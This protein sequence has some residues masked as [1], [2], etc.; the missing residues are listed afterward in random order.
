[1]GYDYDNL[2]K[3]INTLSENYGEIEKSVIGKSVMGRDIFCL[4]SGTGSNNA[5]LL[6]AYH[7]LEYLTS[8]FLMKFLSDFTA[9]AEIGSSFFG[10]TAN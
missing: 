4:N 5:V 7:G 1:M 8:A 2:L 3:D 9:N 10:Y 6:G